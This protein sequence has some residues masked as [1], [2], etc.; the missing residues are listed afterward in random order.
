LIVDD[1]KADRTLYRRYL[2][3]DPYQRYSVF[4]A[5]Y[6][7]EGLALCQDHWFDA[8]L[9]DFQLP[10]MSGLQMLRV[11]KDQY[12][13]IAAIMLTGHGDEQVAVRAMK[14]GAQDYLVKDQL[15]RDVL[16]HTVR[17]VVQQ[18]QLRQQLRK[19]QERQRLIT[20]IAFRIR[21]S[22]D[23]NETLETA[24]TEVRRL[25]ECDRVLVYQFAPDM[26]GQIIAES[27]GKRWTSVLGTTVQDTYFQ[28]HGAED[29]CQGRKQIVSD[30]EAEGLDPCHVALL[31]QFEVRASLVTP[32]LMGSELPASE[33][34]WGLLVAHQCAAVRQWQPDE[35]HILDESSI[36]LSIA[37][38]HAELLT[39]T[40]TALDQEKALN[41]FKS[42]IIA[43]VSHEYNAPLAAIQTAAATLKAHYQNLDTPTRIRFLEIIEQKSKHLSAL[44]REMLLV[45]Q[46]ELNKLKLKP[47]VIN[48]RDFLSHLVTEQQMLG[49]QKHQL[50]LSTRGNL[51]GFVGDR[52]LLRQVFG[53]LLSNAVKYSPEGGKVRVQLM[54]EAA[55][56]VCHVKDNGIGIPKAD[57][58]QLFQSF[59]RGSNVGLIPGTG[60][61][62]HITKVAVELHG[63]TIAVESQEGDGTHVTVRL[64]K[65]LQGVQ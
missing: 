57:Q 60:L 61:G 28:T 19:N 1:S 30:I 32:I 5:S 22:L 56:V 48:L 31:K 11:V 9:L 15:K 40:Q 64:P 36:H 42:K 62:L 50:M 58:A 43:T 65:Q 21:Q 20:N 59:S 24:V 26:S 52:G 49:D 8:V 14:G 39:K 45:N 4:E 34:L 12:P 16:Q 2:L 53:N 6:A 3:Q 18:A 47:T 63:G 38:Q 13:H 41:T 23:L 29:Y 33:Q 44:V 51:D 10:D 27:V 37:I 25:L 54:G 46:A 35:V 55:Q 17:N 7:E